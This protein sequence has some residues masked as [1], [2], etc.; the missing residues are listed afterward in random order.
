MESR[1]CDGPLENQMSVFVY[2]RFDRICNVVGAELLDELGIEV[3]EGYAEI[4]NG[5]SWVQ[6]SSP[7]A[8]A[9]HPT[10]DYFLNRCATP[11]SIG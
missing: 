1:V 10:G 2:M 3:V 8:R 5:M 6:E 11:K 4:E 7:V 9:V